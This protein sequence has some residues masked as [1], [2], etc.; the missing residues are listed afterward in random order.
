MTE[1]PPDRLKRLRMRAWRR[2]T[3]EMDLILGPYA[4]AHL[5]GMDAETVTLFDALL[6]EAD[7]DL[8]AWILGQRDI[9]ARFA[10]LLDDIGAFSRA[11]LQR[12]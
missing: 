12:I 3:K 8:M 10:A 1:T 9:P 7:P 2:G 11:R 5:E 4:D 6:L